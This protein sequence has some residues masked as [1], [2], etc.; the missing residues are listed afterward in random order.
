VGPRRRWIRSPSPVTSVF[1]VVFFLFL[2]FF[3]FSRRQSS[4]TDRALPVCTYAIIIVLAN[5][6][7]T[8]TPSRCSFRPTVQRRYTHAFEHAVL[9]NLA[10]GIAF[11]E[12]RGH[13]VHL[14]TIARGRVRNFLVC[15]F[16]RR[17]SRRRMLSSLSLALF[18]RRVEQRYHYVTVVRNKPVT[19]DPTGFA[20][21]VRVLSLALRTRR[22]CFATRISN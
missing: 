20:R 21:R 18:S 10:I 3:F 4:V 14:R 5:C 19:R 7:P 22:D 17:F 2:F 16:F 12:T 15:S 11:A 8:V 6:L 1:S 13:T 9:R